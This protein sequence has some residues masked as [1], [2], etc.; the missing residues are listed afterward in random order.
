MK[1]A[2]AGCSREGRRECSECSRNFCDAHVET[3]SWCQAFVCFECRDEHDA[4]NPLHD[5]GTPAE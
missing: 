4:N 5:E 1:C 2:T 3:C